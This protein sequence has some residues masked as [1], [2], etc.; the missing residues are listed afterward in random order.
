MTWIVVSMKW[1]ML[2]SGALT[3][4]MLYALVAPEAALEGTFGENLRG[5]W[6]RLSVIPNAC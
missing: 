6:R 4:T 2:V 1:I 5:P 3:C